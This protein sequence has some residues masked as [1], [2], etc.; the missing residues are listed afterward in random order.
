MLSERRDTVIKPIAKLIDP[1]A[2]LKDDRWVGDKPEAGAVFSTL[3][4]V[5]WPS[6]LESLLISLM[7][8]VD[9]IMVSGI[10]A[11]AVAA[12]GLTNQPRMIFYAVLFALNVGVTAVVSRRRGEND[13]EGARRCLAQGILICVCLSVILCA[14]AIAVARPLMV[15]AGAMDDTVD[16]ATMYFRITMVGMCFTS[17]GLIINAAHRGCGNTKI[18]MYTNLTANIVNV[19][20][21]YLLINGVWFFPKLGVKGAAI[22]TLMGN[23]VSCTMSIVSISHKHGYLHLRLRDCFVWDKECIKPLFKVGASAAVEQ[24]F[25]RIG[26]FSYAKMVAALGTTALATHQICMSVISIS[27]SLGDGLGIAAS[28]LVG[29]NL[30]RKRPDMAAVFGKCAQRVG[31]AIAIMLFGL[32]ILGG[33]TIME[34]FSD[35]EII[36][37][38]GKKLL[39]I[40]AF[41][42]QAQISQIVYSGC[43]R[44]AGDTKF[45]ALTSLVSIA[46]VRP[47]LTYVFC[48]P[49]GLGL[50]GAWLSLLVDQYLRLLFASTRFATGKWSSV[51]L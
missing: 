14:A 29:Q 9:T 7:T 22:A 46:L 37:Q 17:L 44:G 18:S 23:I 19:V 45:V 24:V 43:L 42:S 39:V 5:A 47:I 13:R 27:F 3:F 35:E 1:K 12:T 33:E 26:F 38:T 8:F 21:N 25:I 20:F 41:A 4:R 31:M 48:Y 34:L 32:F 30:G 16:D 51:K 36:I 28:A 10:G 50:I 40:T 6:T 15:L 11:S 49:L 2:M